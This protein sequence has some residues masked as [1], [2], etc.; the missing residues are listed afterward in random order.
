MT[1]K[2]SHADYLMLIAAIV[3]LAEKA[4]YGR[5]NTP[6]SFVKA[7]AENVSGGAEEMTYI[8]WNTGMIDKKSIAEL[9]VAKWL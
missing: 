6:L 3:S 5:S 7:F 9:S 8:L 2:K 1:M 4:K